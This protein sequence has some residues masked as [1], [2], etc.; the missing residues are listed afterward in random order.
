MRPTS[1]N[2]CSGIRRPVASFLEYCKNRIC[3]RFYVVSLSRPA[4]SPACCCV[5]SGL[6]R[7]SVPTWWP[8]AG[9][10]GRRRE[11]K[12]RPARQL[13]VCRRVPANH[14]RAPRWIALRFAV[15]KVRAVH[16]HTS[17]SR[18][19]SRR[20]VSTSLVVFAIFASSLHSFETTGVGWSI[21]RRIPAA[22]LKSSSRPMR[23]SW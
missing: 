19:R 14:Q 11:G 1:S 7:F 23:R 21:S 4:V 17:P 15:G 6:P 20:C 22:V 9:L 8:H 16:A 3:C 18:R 5:T 10:T 13:R 2:L 12:S